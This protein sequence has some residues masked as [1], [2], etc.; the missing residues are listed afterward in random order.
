MRIVL[1]LAL[2]T[3]GECDSTKVVGQIGN[4]ITLPCRY[5]AKKHGPVHVCWGRADIPTS[6][7]S[8]Q[9]I[10]TD[11][12]KVIEGTRVSSR[13]Q[14]QRRL[15][16][17]DVSLTILNLTESDAGRYGCRAE[18]PGWFNDLKHHIDL[19]VERAVTTTS[20]PSTRETWSPQSTAN[21]TADTPSHSQMTVTGSVPTSSEGF[22]SLQTEENSSA[23]TVALVCVLFGLIVLVTV[24]VVV[25]IGRKWSRLSKIPQQQVYSSVQFST[26]LQLQSR[27]SAVENIYQIDE[28]G[29][30]GGD[31][32][33]E[34]EYCP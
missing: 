10:A 5:D 33:G 8:D 31:R 26:T 22:S 34:Y 18:I 21:Q 27:G 12:H 30:G 1:L 32:G 25:I 3:V 14:L 6:K 17:G 28:G 2:L 4:N 16:E 19:I 23:L 11:G 20:A 29:D 13:Y 7:C 24:G 9:I 15:D